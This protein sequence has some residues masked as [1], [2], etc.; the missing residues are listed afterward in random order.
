M[1]RQRICFLMALLMVFSLLPFTALAG[2]GGAGW[3]WPGSYS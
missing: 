1:K 3:Y 2:G